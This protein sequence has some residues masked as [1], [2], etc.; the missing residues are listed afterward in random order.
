[1]EVKKVVVDEKPLDCSQ[2]PLAYGHRRD[3]GRQVH[4]NN[5][6]AVQYGKKPDERCKC[7]VR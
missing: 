7:T 2:C 3:C 1:M 6:G 4:K 5:N